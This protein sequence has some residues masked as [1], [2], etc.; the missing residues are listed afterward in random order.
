M[1]SGMTTLGATVAAVALATAAGA[2]MAGA[3]FDE[4]AMNGT[5]TVVSNGEWAQ[6]NER[7]QDQ[8]TVRSTWTVDTV[9]SF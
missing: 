5:F 6:M 3:Q 2:P 8:P 1:R 4:Y 9:C 7:Y